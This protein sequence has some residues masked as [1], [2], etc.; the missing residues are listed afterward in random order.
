MKLSEIEIIKSE[1]GEYPI[2]I[3]DD[4]FSELDENRQRLLINNLKDVQMFITTAENSHKDIFNKNN[5]TIFNIE[6]GKVIK[7]ENNTS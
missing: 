7:V 5:T 4:V 1:S 6:N 2:L 3:L